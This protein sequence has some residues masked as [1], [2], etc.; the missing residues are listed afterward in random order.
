MENINSG[1]KF[2]EGKKKKDYRTFYRIPKVRYNKKKRYRQAYQ[3]IINQAP[4]KMGQL[5][6]DFK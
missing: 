5:V 1:K 6:L 4:V 3:G 2:F